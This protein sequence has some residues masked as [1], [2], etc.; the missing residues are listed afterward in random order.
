MAIQH[1]PAKLCTHMLGVIGL[2][3]VLA[4]CG[5]SQS[6]AIPRMTSTVVRM[7]PASSVP[8]LPTPASDFGFVFRYGVCILGEGELDTFSGQYTQGALV[9]AVMR[10]P[11]ITIPVSL[12]ND[13]FAQI[14]RKMVEIDYF[15]YP[16]QFRVIVPP[17]VQAVGVMP[18]SLYAFK[19]RSNG[20]TKE[21]FWKDDIIRPTTVEADR[22]REL[23]QLIRSIIGAKPAVQMLPRPMGACI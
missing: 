23:A 7:S 2:L 11:A 14:N 16:A 10:E 22:L 19:V 12:T 21:V 8:V 3:L 17:G 9:G 13:E 1:Y 6:T 4:G 18:A 5:A 15:N 20:V